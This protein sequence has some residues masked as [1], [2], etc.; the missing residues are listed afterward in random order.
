MPTAPYRPCAAAQCSILVP[1]GVSRCAAHARQTEQRRG[2]AHHRGY[3]CRDW[4]PFRRRFLAALV[5]AGILPVCGAALP[6][7]PKDRDSACQDAGLFTY[8]SA[9]GS[10]L[11]FD[12]EP[13]LADWE[14]SQPA[15]VCDPTR[16]VLKCAACHARKTG[17]GGESKHSGARASKTA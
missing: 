2:T 5:H 7:G 14:R 10:S 11:H 16:I 8:T 3:T 9:D 1:H 13:P 15:I 12:H 6:D 4:L 17:S